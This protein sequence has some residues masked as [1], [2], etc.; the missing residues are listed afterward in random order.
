M[1]IIL[2]THINNLEQ[3]VDEFQH[4]DL[5]FRL[6]GTGGFTGR[7]KQLANQEILITYARFQNGLDQSGTAPPGYRTFVIP[8][9][10]CNGF[11][12][13]GHNVTRDDLLVFP[14][15]NELQCASNKDFEVF[16]ISLQTSYLEQLVNKLG[17]NGF[18][19]RGREVIRLE[20]SAAD[21]LR[22]LAGTIVR[23]TDIVVTQ[24]V[25]HAL[26]ERLIICTELDRP[27]KI[28]SLRK[29]DLAVDRVVEYVRSNQDLILEL[30]QLC[31]IARVSERTLQYA[32]KDRY[33]IPPNVFV[34]KWKLN[35]ARRL[36]LQ[37][38]PAE[39]TVIDIASRLGFLHQGQFAADYR[40]L[41]AE[42]PSNTLAK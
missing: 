14:N 35:S 27:E 40:T 7:V 5:D 12:W 6:L 25:A 22:H 39:T 15:S 33:G 2:D 18:W 34:K 10:N 37:A 13:R 38:D 32:F 3:F 29:R 41:F 23:H 31:R 4:W 11:W 19:D 8:G 28:S 24:A 16:S 21:S 36:L 26:A 20:G 30:A 1:Q 9:R 42:L 17:V